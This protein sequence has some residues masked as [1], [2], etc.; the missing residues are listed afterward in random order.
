MGT[1]K[2][3]VEEFPQAPTDHC[4]SSAS[5]AC[6]SLTA[7]D[8]VWTRGT[9]TNAADPWQTFAEDAILAGPNT[10]HKR[11]KARSF[12]RKAQH[13]SDVVRPSRGS[14]RTELSPDIQR[15]SLAT[16]G[17]KHSGIRRVSGSPNCGRLSFAPKQAPASQ[18]LAGGGISDGSPTQ[19]LSRCSSASSEG[20]SDYWERLPNRWS[21]LRSPSFDVH[22][23][24]TLGE[25][26]SHNVS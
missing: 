13:R 3:G 11:K 26:H 1:L 25:Q 5:P 16:K 2:L 6:A 15:V 9:C 18:R 19:G 22:S 8:D 24:F 7:T 10:V 4:T 12:D 21:L 20:G 14:V 23:P 17:R